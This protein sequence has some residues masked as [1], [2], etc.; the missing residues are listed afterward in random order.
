MADAER[1][2]FQVEVGRLIRHARK[3]RSILQEDLARKVGLSP[4]A[5]SNFERGRRRI[6]LGWLRRIGKALGV[7]VADLIPESRTRRP[8]ATSTDEEALLLAWRRLAVDP[9]L[10]ESVL[11]F[12]ERLA[13]GL[14][15]SERRHG[16]ERP[17]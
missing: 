15:E 7:P 11:E 17:S 13:V 1:N 2:P 5:L 16:P 8:I 6:S 4:S 14:R 3:R 12:F 10:Q 9:A